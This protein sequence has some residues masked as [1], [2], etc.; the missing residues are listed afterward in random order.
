M[1]KIFR[2]QSSEFSFI[3]N[4]AAVPSIQKF[5]LILYNKNIILQQHEFWLGYVNDN[6]K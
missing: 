4:K 5:N 1:R 2:S 3:F 6:E